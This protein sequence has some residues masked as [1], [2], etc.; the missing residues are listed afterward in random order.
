MTQT[1][2]RTS[3]Q[4]FTSKVER[5]IATKLVQAIHK[6]GFVISVH[7]GE[8]FN[9]EDLSKLASVRAHLATTGED[10]LFFRK[11]G[12]TQYAGWIWLIFGNGEDLISDY[13]ANETTEAL[14]A[15]IQ[16]WIES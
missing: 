4:R 3:F 8:E 15:P 7:D 6:A 12:E 14:V 2:T 10:R 1:D 11:P 9:C 16:D 5:G 13:T